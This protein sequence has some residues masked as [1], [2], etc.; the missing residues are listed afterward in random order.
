MR[1]AAAVMSA[2]ASASAGAA[3]AAAGGP[4]QRAL[5]SALRA[6]PLAPVHLA[7]ENESSR[8]AGGPGRE[9]HFK[10]LVVSAA[11]QGLPPLARHRLV[12]AAVAPPAAPPVHALSISAVTP[13]QWAAGA[14]LHATPDCRG[15]SA[16]EAR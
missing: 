3:G 2:A 12:H 16:A 10:V 4:V 15:G 11:F 5:V 14:S 1:A 8:H 9:S 13:A 7:I 6:S